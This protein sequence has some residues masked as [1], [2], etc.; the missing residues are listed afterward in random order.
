MLH[1]YW[2]SGQYVF[3]F[4]VHFLTGKQTV[5]GAKLVKMLKTAIIFAIGK[6]AQE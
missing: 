5:A 6:E 1:G 3:T 4:T 2:M